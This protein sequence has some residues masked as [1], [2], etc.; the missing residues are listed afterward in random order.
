MSSKT[1]VKPST[2]P[3]APFH[4]IRIIIFLSSIVIGII[5][6]IFIYHLH[7]DGFKLPFAFLIVSPRA[8][9]S[10]QKVMNGPNQLLISTLLSILNIIFTALITSTCGLSTKLS[11]ML[12]ALLTILW[13]LSLALMAYSMAHTILTSCTVHYWANH[14]GIAVC[15]GYKALFAFTVTGTASQIAAL[16]LDL[17]VR[18]RQTRLGVYDAMGSTTGGL[19]EDA[20]DVKLA[21]RAGQSEPA[22]S[23]DK[24]YEAVP[25]P[26]SGA[27]Q[28]GTPYAQT[29]ESGHA[30]E[31]A[32]F[33][34]TAPARSRRGAPRVSYRSYGQMGY[35]PAMYR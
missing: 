13:L 1:S 33:Y 16:W 9:V 4:G 11:I 6:A 19:G 18:R 22:Y 12:N 17:V 34:D 3:P 23:P 10:T 26:M 14:T 5:L 2:Y 30:G 27:Q 25:P 8:Y 20:M 24:R 35:D 29:L 32:M 31:A 21:D 15:R 7:A 28:Y